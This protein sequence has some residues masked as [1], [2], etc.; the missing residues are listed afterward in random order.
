VY[1]C[2]HSLFLQVAVDVVVAVGP[3]V[4]AEVPAVDVVAA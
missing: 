2:L 4:V 3:L 1:S